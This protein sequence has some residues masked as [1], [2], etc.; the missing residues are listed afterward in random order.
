MKDSIKTGTETL[1]DAQISDLIERYFNAE[2]SVEEEAAL[3]C[4][5]AAN[6]DP[7][8]DD[9]RAVLGYV[10]VKKSHRNVRHV[11]WG[12]RAVRVAAMVAVVACM[13]LSVLM[14]DG[15]G[16]NSDASGNDCY[17]YVQG[18]RVDD[19]A[20]VMS[21]VQDD[22]SDIREAAQ[23]TDNDMQSQLND[24]REAFKDVNN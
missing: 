18:K 2:I 14:L 9:I 11:Q 6:S 5:V 24:I 19:P 13:G 12:R 15:N 4:A 10:A 22:F 17:A 3:K 21:L 16:G 23:E 1:A 20:H 7:R 8:Y